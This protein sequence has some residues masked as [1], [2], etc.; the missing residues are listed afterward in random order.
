[1]SKQ[2]WKY[3]SKGSIFEKAYSKSIKKKAPRVVISE[4]TEV[5]GPGIGIEGIRK[6]MQEKQEGLAKDKNK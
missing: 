4:R 1:M 5:R 6:M 2:K 3:F